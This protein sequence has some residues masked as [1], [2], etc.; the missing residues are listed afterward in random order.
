[1]SSLQQPRQEGIIWYQKQTI[2]QQCFRSFISNR[3]EKTQVFMNKTA[4]VGLSILE[5]SKIVKYEFWYDYVTPNF[6]KK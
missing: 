4:Y 2:I 5:I 1:M 6:G 3:N